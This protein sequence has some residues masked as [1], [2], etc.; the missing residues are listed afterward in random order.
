MNTTYRKLSEN[1]ITVLA[2]NGCSAEDWNRIE[3]SDGFDAGLIRHCRFGGNVKLGNRVCINHVHNEISNYV[4]GDDVTIKNIESLA[5]IGES[6]FGNGVKVTVLNETGGRE[7][8]IFDK[9]SAQTAYVL[10]VYQ[11]RPVTIQN[12]KSFIKKYQQEVTSPVGTIGRG[13][14]ITN[15][16]SLTNVRIG[17]KAVLN[18][19]SELTNGTVDSREDGPTVIGRG[20]I[21]RDFIVLS[22]SEIADYAIVEKCFIGQGCLIGKGFTAENSLFFA[23]C[24]CMSGEACAVF[25]GPYTVT[26]HKS[27]LLIGGMFSFYNAGSGTNQSNHMYKLGPVHQGVLERGVKTSSSSYILFPARIGAFSVVK[28][29]HYSN[30][31]TSALPFS[32]L[33]EQNN[34]SILIPAINLGSSGTARDA[35]KWPQ[36]DMRKGEVLDCVNFKMLNPYTVSK[37]KQGIEILRGLN[38]LSNKEYINYN[39]VKVAGS[40]IRKGMDTYQLAIDKYIGGALAGKL[41]NSKW[42]SASDINEIIDMG[43]RSNYGEWADIAGLITPVAVVNRVMNKI[44]EGEI[45]NIEQLNDAFK[46]LHKNYHEFEW[47]YVVRLMAALLEKPTGKITVK[48]L[49]GILSRWKDSVAK[50]DKMLLEDAFKEF[51]DTKKVSYGIDGDKTTRELDFEN[52]RGKREENPFIKG[53]YEHTSQKSIVADRL[54]NALSAL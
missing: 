20:V 44:D 32:Y 5:T 53:T 15:C 42:K 39:N 1:E 31:D 19:V 16:G 23:N 13:S 25:A 33:I 38:S 10:A 54:I 27:T 11:H 18:G 3:V 41:Q 14:V 7:V 34:E 46:Y 47:V 35:M 12:I 43:S 49:I 36:R 24:V 8:P 29:R 50:I 6:S 22:S 40:S 48:D 2:A 45:N 28:G 51:A 52:V 9:L 21:A 17:E 37:L 30:S 26:H 4:I